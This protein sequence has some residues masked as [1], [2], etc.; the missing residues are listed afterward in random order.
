MKRLSDHSFLKH[1][2][3]VP[4]HINKIFDDIDEIQWAKNISS[5]LL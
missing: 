1:I 5:C 2:E 4:F 3:S